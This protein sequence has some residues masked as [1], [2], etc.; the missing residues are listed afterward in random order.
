MREVQ[1]IKVVLGNLNTWH[2]QQSLCLPDNQIDA[3]QP[4]IVAE[5]TPLSLLRTAHSPAP[6]A[7][8]LCFCVN[9]SVIQL[10]I[11]T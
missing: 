11:R 3:I 10:Y 8:H 4:K 5:T 1:C 9:V 2:C 6:S 7:A